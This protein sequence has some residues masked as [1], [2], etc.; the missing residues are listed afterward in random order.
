MTA[1]CAA[2]R[3]RARVSV[4]YRLRPRPLISTSASADMSVTGSQ[5][6]TEWSGG[7]QLTEV[8]RAGRLA[9][10]RSIVMDHVEL[11]RKV[12]STSALLRS[13]ALASEPARALAPG[14]SMG[15][16]CTVANVSGMR[17]VSRRPRPTAGRGQFARPKIG[18]HVTPGTAGDSGRGLLPDQGSEPAELRRLRGQAA[19]RLPLPAL[20]FCEL[21]PVA[22][23]CNRY[24]EMPPLS[25]GEKSA[26]ELE[27][28][29]IGAYNADGQPSVNRQRG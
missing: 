13:A 1:A 18:L 17:R 12:L 24:R 15:G 19:L 29:Q 2:A 11:A 7:C 20:F 28:Q 21:H 25:G 26:H 14:E 23:H 8:R 22:G 27:L 3:P 16:G 9:V 6:A 10:K 5:E 4:T